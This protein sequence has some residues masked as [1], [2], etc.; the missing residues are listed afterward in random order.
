[1]NY[2]CVILSKAKYLA[3]FFCISI[4]FAQGP[5]SPAAG[6]AGSN[7]I[8]RD[9][10]AITGWASGCSIQRGYQDISDKPL[11]M[12]DVGNNA[13][14]IG[15]ADGDVV[16][17]GDSGVAVLTF[18]VPI[19]NTLGPDF[20]V[21]E[22]SFDDAF[23]E[24]A[25]VEVSSDGI[26]FYRF[27]AISLT[28]TVTQTASFGTSDPTNIYNLA[29]KY[30]AMYGTPFDLEELKDVVGL[31]VNNVTHVKIIDVIGTINNNYCTRD[32]EGR[33]INDPY[34]TAFSPGGFDL[35]GV[36]VLGDVTGVEELNDEVFSIYPNPSNGVF[37]FSD[38]KIVKYSIVNAL[39]RVVCVGY[40]NKIDISN[41][42]NGV[43]FLEL[44]EQVI[45]LVK[46]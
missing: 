9:F 32:S 14:G 27:D 2:F 7:A 23:L 17:L 3:G 1:M 13:S 39:G 8:H 11:G 10:F 19:T 33:K 18:T 15:Y 12:T 35:D 4:S 20:A 43:Y 40:D 29:G 30:R 36:A 26:N 38:N 16:S 22:N 44:N 45:R 25:F 5:Y 41:L 24:L 34:P 31:N 42:P 46:Q 6:Q 37:Y 28:D 21:F